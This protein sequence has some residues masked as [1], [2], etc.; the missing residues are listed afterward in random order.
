MLAELCRDNG[1]LLIMDEVLT[2]FRITA[3]GW[4]RLEG[5]AAT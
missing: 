1:A 2:G 3:S 4:F 5:V